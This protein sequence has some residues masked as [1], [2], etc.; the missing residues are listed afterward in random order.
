MSELNMVFASPTVNCFMDAPD[1]L[2][3]CENLKEYLALEPVLCERPDVHYPVCRLGDLTIHAVHYKTFEEFREIWNRRKARVHYDRIFLIFTDR[4]GFTEVMLPR[5]AQLPHRKVLFAK[6]DYPGYDFVCPLSGY[7]KEACV[8]NVTD[9]RGCTGKR[10]YARYPF[11][12]TFLAMMK[13]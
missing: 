9:Y 7:A 5:I 2:K 10:V 3:F 1:F 4:D 6:R 13:K 12:Q 8:G 11:V